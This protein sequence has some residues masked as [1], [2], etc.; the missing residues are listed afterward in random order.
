M[1]IIYSESIQDDHFISNGMT[2]LIATGLFGS[3]LWGFCGDRFGAINLVMFYCFLDF[4]IKFYSCFIHNK[5]T[6][7]F[8]MTLLGLTDKMILTL[9]GPALIEAFGL[10]RASK[11]LTYKF[12]TLLASIVLASGLRIIFSSISS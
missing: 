3:A 2:V 4:A 5:I 8:A 6:F 1:K 7:M 10:Y 11:L 9:F 12:M